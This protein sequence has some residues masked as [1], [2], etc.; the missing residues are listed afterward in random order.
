MKIWTHYKSALISRSH[1]KRVKIH[2]P[3]EHLTAKELNLFLKIWVGCPSIFLTKSDIFCFK[4]EKNGFGR[5]ETGEIKNVNQLEKTIYFIFFSAKRQFFFIFSPSA[6]LPRLLHR[7]CDSKKFEKYTTDLTAEMT[8]AQ[9]ISK[10]R[11]LSDPAGCRKV[12][13]LACARL[14]SVNGQPK[15]NWL[16]N[17]LESYRW[18]G[19]HDL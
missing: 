14:K 8:T 12:E 2:S 3:S 7:S 17:S 19:W 4:P 1:D 6:P 11:F 15:Y 18:W 9:K 5:S 13:N 16:R 10:N